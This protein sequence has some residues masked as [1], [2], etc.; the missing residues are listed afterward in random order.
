[1]R[2]ITQGGSGAGGKG[3]A[4]EMRYW[5]RGAACSLVRFRCQFNRQ[6]QGAM[7]W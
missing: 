1:M 2:W 6:L 5:H 3:I 7:F 4:V